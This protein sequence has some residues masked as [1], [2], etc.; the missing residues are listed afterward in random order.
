MIVQLA[1]AVSEFIST[2]CLKSGESSSIYCSL[3][4]LQLQDVM[5]SAPCWD[6]RV[7]HSTH[8]CVPTWLGSQTLHN[9]N[10]VI[11]KKMT[12]LEAL[13]RKEFLVTPKIFSANPV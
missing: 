2:G 6:S 5:E 1:G 9:I 3:L 12:L 7:L 10:E 13:N 11:L 8:G 4:F